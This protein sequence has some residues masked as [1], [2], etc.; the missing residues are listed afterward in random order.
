MSLAFSFA[1]T[2]KSSAA[3]AEPA[4]EPAAQTPQST[5]I[6]ARIDN[7]S[8]K[9]IKGVLKKSHCQLQI[10][11][12]AVLLQKP[13]DMST[14]LATTPPQS[15]PAP[16]EEAGTEQTTKA[17]PNVDATP[18]YSLSKANNGPML[19]AGIS[20]LGFSGGSLIDY[21]SRIAFE[22]FSSPTLRLRGSREG[23]TFGIG[24]AL[25]GFTKMENL[26]WVFSAKD[27]RG[28]FGSCF[29]K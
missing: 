22:W 27:F 13:L 23:F 7:I 1:V 16:D 10:Q 11:G 3:T 12:A 28:E 20:R 6:P 9:T 25:R 15:A 21:H 4:A 26:D 18:R 29:K 8:G 2:A 19:L 17:K 14:Q 5:V 24:P